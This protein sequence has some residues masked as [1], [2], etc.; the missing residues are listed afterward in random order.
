MMTS[1]IFPEK[2]KRESKCFRQITTFLEPEE[3]IQ[4]ILGFCFGR[5]DELEKPSFHEEKFK[6]R[7]IRHNVSYGKGLT[8]HFLFGFEIK[9]L[10]D[11]RNSV[12]FQFEDGDSLGFFKFLEEIRELFDKVHSQV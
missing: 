7:S 1:L 12:Q 4:L 3:A 5:K 10:Q 2:Q 11:E 6:V 8:T 9:E